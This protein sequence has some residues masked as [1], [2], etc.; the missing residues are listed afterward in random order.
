M[1]KQSPAK[2]R[3]SGD[4]APER[5]A[6]PSR[7]ETKLFISFLPE[8]KVGPREDKGSVPA[9]VDVESHI[10]E[11]SDCDPGVYRIEKRRGGEFSKETW[12]YTKD[13]LV[14]VKSVRSVDD[15][16]DQ[17]GSD[18]LLGD[19]L[20]QVEEIETELPGERLLRSL[21]LEGLSN[22]AQLTVLVKRTPDPIGMSFRVPCNVE[23][24][25]GQIPYDENDPSVEALDLSIQRLYG[26]GRYKVVIRQ[27]GKIVGSVVRT[28]LDHPETKRDDNPIRVA[29]PSVPLAT[30]ES[31]LEDL[32]ASVRL[33]QEHQSVNPRRREPGREPPLEAIP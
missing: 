12:H 7:G 5:V 19:D 25:A 26:G 18:D 17:S 32:K 10:E 31:P 8:G 15:D 27:D 2:H 3:E 13:A 20:P 22:D 1:T 14:G 28:I 30:V 21:D 4:E 6:R 23:C 9:D 16:L 33:V 24:T 11:R 29:Q